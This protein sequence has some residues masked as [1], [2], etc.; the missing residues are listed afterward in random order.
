MREG[1]ESF[2]D[3]KEHKEFLHKKRQER[4][5]Q[6]ASSAFEVPKQNMPIPGQQGKWM[7]KSSS[8]SSSYAGSHFVSIYG[9]LH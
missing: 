9:V 8:S 4:E 7:Q 1:G 2:Q 5:A 6:T 3:E